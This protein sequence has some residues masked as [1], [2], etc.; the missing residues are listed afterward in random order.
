[1]SVFKVA[2]NNINQGLLDRDP[3]TATAGLGPHQNVC[4]SQIDPSI[5]RT[6]YVMGPNLVNRK[7][8]DGTTFTDCNYWKKFA[9]PQVPYNEA[10]IEVVTDDGSVYSDIPSENTYPVV[11]R[12]GTSGVIADN[13]GPD[14]TNM[15]LDITGTYGGFASF[16]Q[17][18]NSDSSDSV[19][20]RL[21]GLSGATFTLAA[22]STQIFNAGDLS[23]S[24]IAFDNSASG[25]GE[26]D[27]V[28]VL[29]SIRSVCNS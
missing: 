17:I 7:L 16:V 15:T 19:Q 6:V 1:M 9:Y 11:F 14:D 3:S 10:F 12:P 18:T 21:N 28:E 4:G 5:Q 25:A 13:A 22:D 24:E 20:V 23:I 2:L 29:L 26:V 8:T 27:S